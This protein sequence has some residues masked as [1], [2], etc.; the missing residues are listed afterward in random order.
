MTNKS[1]LH[2][3]HCIVC[4]ISTQTKGKAACSA[5]VKRQLK[6]YTNFRV[7]EADKHFCI[8]LC[9]SWK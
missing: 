3:I 2:T 8:T 5:N 4:N 7:L 6:H 9:V 1:N